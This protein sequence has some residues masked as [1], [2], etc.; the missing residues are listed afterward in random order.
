MPNWKKLITSGSNASLASLNVSSAITGSALT[1]SGN[2]TVNN[3]TSS[4]T[5]S[6]SRLILPVGTDLWAT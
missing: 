3:L 2:S 4:G 5:I 1:I 6:G